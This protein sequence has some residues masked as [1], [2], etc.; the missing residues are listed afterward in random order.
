[1]DVSLPR[2]V[3]IAG[4]WGLGTWVLANRWALYAS[5]IGFA[6]YGLGAAANAVTMAVGLP[7]AAGYG[8]SY[9]I[10]GTQG[11]E[12]YEYFLTHPFDMPQNTAMAVANIYTHYSGQPN[13]TGEFDVLDF[14][15]VHPGV[16]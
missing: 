9:A 2:D 7:V 10:A 5:R 1:M 4:T 11:I 13:S 8:L 14:E 12:D 16:M 3:A 6:G 15:G